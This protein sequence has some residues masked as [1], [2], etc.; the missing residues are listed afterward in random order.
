LVPRLI[1]QYEETL[2]RVRGSVNEKPLQGSGIS[3]NLRE[4]EKRT[5]C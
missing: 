4:Q 3:F 2:H 5:M 1:R